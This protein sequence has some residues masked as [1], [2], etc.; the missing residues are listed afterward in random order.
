MLLGARLRNDR[1][2]NPDSCVLVGEWLGDG[3]S[4][5]GLMLYRLAMPFIV[6][7]MSA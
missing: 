3:V 2:V 6:E 5:I 1:D 7:Q 4:D